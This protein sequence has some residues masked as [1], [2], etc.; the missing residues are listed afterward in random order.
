MGIVEL[1]ENAERAATPTMPDTIERSKKLIVE[2]AEWQQKVLT[3][4]Y[5]RHYD[6]VARRTIST[7]A[8]F[9]MPSFSR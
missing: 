6:A 7:R 5:A 2:V 9:L 4:E 1:A 8:P 3:P